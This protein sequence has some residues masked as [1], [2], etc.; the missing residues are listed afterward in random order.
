LSARYALT[1]ALA[2][3]GSAGRYFRAPTLV[4]LY[5]DRGF[6]VG[7]ATLAPETGVSGDLGVVYA[8]DVRRGVFDRLF[9]EAALFAS[10]PKNLISWVTTSAQT[11]VATNIADAR[12][13]GLELSLAA[14]AF[15]AL[16]LTG[17]Y[18]LLDAVQSSAQVTLDGNR[19]PGR[20][21]HDVYARLDAEH[22]FARIGLAAHVDVSYA[23]GVFH[24]VGNEFIHRV[25]DRLFLGVGARASFAYGLALALECRN[26]FDERVE[27][28]PLPSE[29]L[30]LTSFPRAVSDALG[31]PLP[32]RS[33]MLSASA[34]F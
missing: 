28:V 11:T 1:P 14:R 17:N 23:S 12:L 6:L 15:G 22:A 34:D 33:L 25:P 31:Y 27:D 24:D 8:P 16:T 32:G 5:G 13:V 2:L 7:N 20:P 10:R 19:L 3:K 30:G 29:T 9:V 18:T 4:E 26:L 21:R